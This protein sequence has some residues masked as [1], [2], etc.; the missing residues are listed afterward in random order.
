MLY[1]TKKTEGYAEIMPIYE[2]KCD[3]CEHKIEVRQG[4]YDE[5]CVTCPACGKDAL[6]KLF[7][8]FTPIYKGPGFHTTESRGITGRKRKPN[9]KVGLKADLPQEE[10]ERM[11]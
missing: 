6:R 2:Y 9:I 8:T 4:F 1:T 7:S 11:S 5:P 3:E 10:Q